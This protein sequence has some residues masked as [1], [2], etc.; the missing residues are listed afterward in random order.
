MQFRNIKRAYGQLEM[1][2]VHVP[3][4][5]QANLLSTKTYLP[6]TII[7]KNIRSVHFTEKLD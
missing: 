3:F 7:N 6:I 1:K 5:S 4:L 2:F